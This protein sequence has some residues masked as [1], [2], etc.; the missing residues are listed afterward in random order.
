M[1]IVIIGSLLILSVL[2]GNSLLIEESLSTVNVLYDLKTDTMY[3][4]GDVFELQNSRF[5]NYQDQALNFQEVIPSDGTHIDDNNCAEVEHLV[6]PFSA[7]FWM[8]IILCFCKSL[9]NY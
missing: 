2:S 4:G 1:M 9:L 6:I 3:Y 8:Y 7:E 5:H